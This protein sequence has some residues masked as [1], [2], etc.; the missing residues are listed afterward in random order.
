MV[1]DDEEVRNPDIPEAQLREEH[2]GWLG[3]TPYFLVIAPR[4][5]K[6]VQID[7]D[8]RGWL[9]TYRAYLRAPGLWYL[10]RKPDGGIIVTMLVSDGEQPYYVARHVGMVGVSGGENVETV[11]YGIGKKRLDGHVDRFWVLANGSMTFGDDVENIALNLL[12][13]GFL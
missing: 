4:S 11:C 8:E 1:E 6:P 2:G 5:D 9:G 13:Q 7:L 10:A 12:R 3:P